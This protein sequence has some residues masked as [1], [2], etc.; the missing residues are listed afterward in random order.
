MVLPGEKAGLQV[1]RPSE[2]TRLP[3]AEAEGQRHLM[4]GA[5]PS[6]FAIQ[7]IALQELPQKLL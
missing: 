5:A 6:A 1:E 7:S 4:S 2:A 3:S